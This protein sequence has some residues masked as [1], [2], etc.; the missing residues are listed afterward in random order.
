MSPA[1]HLLIIGSGPREY[2][3]QLF[4]SLS[5]ERIWLL[6]ATEPTWQQPYISGYTVVPRLNSA[7]VGTK[8]AFLVSAA[9]KLAAGVEIDGVLTFEEMFLPATCEIAEFLGLATLGR[10]ATENCRNKELTRT[11]LTEAGIPQPRFAFV[12]SAGEAARFGRQF[13]FPVVF[14]PRGLG[15][16][17]GVFMA[18]SADE[19]DAGYG[20]AVVAARDG[21]Q[22]HGGG[23]L[24][25]EFLAGPE[26]SVDC[27]VVSGAVTPLFLA[28]K[29]FGPKPFFEETGQTIDAHDPLLTD[30]VLC[31]M[32]Q[33]AHT[34]LGVDT[35]MTHTEVK[36]TPDG[37]VI[38]EVNGR[39]AGGYISHLAR[40]A[41]GLD[42]AMIAA[43][44]ARGRPV[45][46]RHSA[47][48][49][50]AVYILYAQQAG[51]VD[52]ITLPRPHEHP[53]LVEAGPLVAKGAPV[54]LPPDGYMARCAYAIVAADSPYECETALAAAVADMSVRVVEPELV[55]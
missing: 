47:A 11:A 7:Q 1:A 25:E 51:T 45:D 10:Q 9:E 3:E 55:S 36:L 54:T 2:R 6:C 5:T 30:P 42:G 48:R 20:V 19:I 22:R 23:A 41:M 21:A 39:M 17:L 29:K 34:A 38:V 12:T 53:C 43:D 8:F 24:V 52:T 15:G 35:G 14:K 40:H 28:R 31:R 27:A 16:S 26:I 32:L 44:V 33:A 50:A 13:G 18:T 4:R 37:P 49:G 46:A